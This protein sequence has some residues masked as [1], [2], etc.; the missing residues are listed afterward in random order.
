PIPPHSFPTRR[1][2]DLDVPARIHRSFVRLAR[3][4]SSGRRSPTTAARTRGSDA[5]A[6]FFDAA[7]FSFSALFRLGFGLRTR[8][9]CG[10]RASRSEEH[11][12]ELQSQ[13]NL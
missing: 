7:R 10:F 5:L 9:F 13:S 11:T 1:S 3:G 8:F 6:I 4:R 12:S 2:S